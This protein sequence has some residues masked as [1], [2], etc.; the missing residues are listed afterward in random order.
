MPWN[1]GKQS[2][3][4]AA[5]R[6][7]GRPEAPDVLF[8]GFSRPQIHYGLFQEKPRDMLGLSEGLHLGSVFC[9]IPR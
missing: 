7:G 5:L 6:K 2:G 9:Q 4:E 8:L 3:V 1:C